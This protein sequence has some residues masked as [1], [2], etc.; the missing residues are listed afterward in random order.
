MGD[1][2]CRHGD[3]GKWGQSTLC[4]EP[5]IPDTLFGSTSESPL[6]LVGGFRWTGREGYNIG[7]DPADSRPKRGEG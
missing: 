4:G 7:L 5:R 6:G 1:K 3:T 2:S